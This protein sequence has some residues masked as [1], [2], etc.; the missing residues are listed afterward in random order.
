[1]R[2]VR[3]HETVSGFE[4]LLSRLQVADW[5]SANLTTLDQVRRGPFAGPPSFRPVTRTHI[6]IRY[7]ASPMGACPASGLE[8]T[9]RRERGRPHKYRLG[10]A[11]TGNQ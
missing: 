8:S 4:P 6:C 10:S 1:M 9:C 11:D 5:L 2:S 7:A 3:K